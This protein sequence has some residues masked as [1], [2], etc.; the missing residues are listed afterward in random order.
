MK[1]SYGRIE[2][3]KRNKTCQEDRNSMMSGRER[4]T[5]GS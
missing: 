5:L 2:T 1:D 3:G 4:G